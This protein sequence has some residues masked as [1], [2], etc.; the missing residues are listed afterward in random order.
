MLD[1]KFYLCE[2]FQAKIVN[3]PIIFFHIPKCG[4]TTFCNLLHPLFN[5]KRIY[6]S[7]TGERG[8]KSA[9]ENFIESKEEIIKSNFQFIYGH[10]QYEIKS[11]FNN[12]LSIA[13]LREP[14]ERAISHYNML[15][16][17][18][19]IEKKMSLA[20]CYKLN[21]MPSNVMT[22][23][24]S[25]KNNSDLVINETDL[26]NA[27]S[28][29]EQNVDIVVDL[30]DIIN[31]L[32][33]IISSYNLPNLLFQ[34]AQQTKKNYFE[35]NKINLEIVMEY[36]KYD[37]EMYSK[38]SKTEVFK[39]TKTRVM[40]KYFFSSNSFNLDGKKR[41]VLDKSAYNELTKFMS[42]KKIGIKKIY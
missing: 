8:G 5:S 34:K 29:L 13:V 11:F 19:L 15:V 21:I 36:N 1:T 7:P 10:F 40:D 23:I 28:N 14:I 9:F 20:D 26:R 22:Q 24:F 32:N 33:Y 17:R 42:N 16:E 31:L 30:K 2:G 18:K 35:N 25:K 39:S 27:I 38:V 3:K 12:F 6:G 4:G 41:L 37:L